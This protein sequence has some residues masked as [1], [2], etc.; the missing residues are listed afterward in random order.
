MQDK[1][2]LELLQGVKFFNTLSQ[3]TTQLTPRLMKNLFKLTLLTLN[4]YQDAYSRFIS[5]LSMDV[6]YERHILPL[7]A[8]YTMDY[9]VGFDHPAVDKTSL[10][11]R[12][13]LFLCDLAKTISP[14]VFFKRFALKEF[15]PYLGERKVR[16]DLL[17]TFTMFEV[18]ILVFA[19]QNSL[20]LATQKSLRSNQNR[21]YNDPSSQDIVISTIKHLLSLRFETEKHRLHQYISLLM[22]EKVL[23]VRPIIISY[24]MDN[25]P[26]SS[27]GAPDQDEATPFR[28]L[29][30]FQNIPD[31]KTCLTEVCSHFLSSI[32][33]DAGAVLDHVTKQAEEAK[34]SDDKSSHDAAIFKVIVSTGTLLDLIDNVVIKPAHESDSD[35]QECLK[36]FTVMKPRLNKLVSYYMQM[37]ELITKLQPTDKALK[38]GTIND[39]SYRIMAIPFRY[40]TQLSDLQ[41][42]KIVA[43]LA[44][45]PSN[46]SPKSLVR[47][48][49]SVDS[50]VSLQQPSAALD[51]DV[52]EF[53][54]VLAEWMK[55]HKD[56]IMKA[57]A[58]YTETNKDVKKDT[59]SFY[60]Q[61]STKF[62]WII[63]F[64]V[65]K[66]LL[67]YLL[68]CGWC[69]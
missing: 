25:S 43:L 58:I 20:V 60:G 30:L 14:S 68:H 53:G 1:W 67:M 54:R 18:L 24:T 4:S 32:L 65:K 12:M 55:K 61:L 6:F 52:A 39:Q 64:E 29:R 26:S 5:S 13:L 62:P 27:E 17:E 7:L 40:Y 22:K 35:R 57:Y 9:V 49:S 16:G 48:L 8:L 66:Q 21:S 37:F 15:G 50:F 59:N 41:N 42:A 69:R 51:A 10:K 28:G 36:N 33:E 3:P 44:A 34:A 45:S 23:P 63:S 46:K 56:I 31:Y 11:A 38:Q 47:R 19:T 2:Y